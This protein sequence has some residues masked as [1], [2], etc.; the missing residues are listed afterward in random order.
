MV[1][2]NE[3]DEK[4][5][6]TNSLSEKKNK[7]LKTRKSFKVSSHGNSSIDSQSLSRTKKSSEFDGPKSYDNF[8]ENSNNLPE[9][10]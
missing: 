8:S 10:Y 5:S 4:T 9:H 3:N 2:E 6:T 1:I 7:K